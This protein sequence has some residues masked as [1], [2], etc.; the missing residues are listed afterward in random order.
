[1]C[2]KDVFAALFA[3]FAIKLDFRLKK[4]FETNVFKP[5][6]LFIVFCNFY[7]AVKLALVCFGRVVG[8]SDCFAYGLAQIVL[9]HVVGLLYAVV[10]CG[11]L[12]A[13]VSLDDGF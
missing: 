8:H 10:N 3:G 2:K 6:V 12:A 5:L 9:F 11:G 13:A 1:M 4:R 7:L